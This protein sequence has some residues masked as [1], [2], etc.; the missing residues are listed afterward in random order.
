[1]GPRSPKPHRASNRLAE[2]HP[3]DKPEHVAGHLARNLAALRHA[4]TLTQ[5]SLA[6]A[7]SVP[8][9][10]IANLESGVGNPSLT[11]LMNVATA[12]GVPIDELLASPRAKVR[13]WAASDIS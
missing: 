12:L 3:M 9:S 2:R 11:V 10:T 1:M 6:R 13:K 7:S 5:E 4:R 8:R